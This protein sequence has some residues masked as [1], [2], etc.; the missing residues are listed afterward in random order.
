MHPTNPYDIR[1][2]PTPNETFSI[3]GFNPYAPQ[4]N[5]SNCIVDFYRVPDYTNSNPAISLPPYILR[6]TQKAYVLWK[7]FAAEGKGQDLKASQYYGAKY[8]F[9]VEQF[10]KINEGAFV[11]KKYTV[12]DGML[13]IDNFRYPRPLLPSQ[14]ERVQF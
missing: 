1:L 14:F 5:Q 6:R 9:L 7:A 2:Y 11:G 10:R 12:D 8:D 3:I 13:S 4:V